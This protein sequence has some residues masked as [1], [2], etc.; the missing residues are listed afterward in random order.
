[1]EPV[2][3]RRMAEAEMRVLVE[4]HP[5]RVNEKDRN[6]ETILYVAA[7]MN[8]S[9]A[10][11]SWLV[12]RGADV[13][14][15]TTRTSWGLTPLHKATSAQAVDILLKAGASPTC[16]TE[17]NRNTPL[18]THCYYLKTVCVERLLR[19]PEVIETID[20]QDVYGRTG[21]FLACLNCKT[22]SNAFEII[23]MLLRAG[24]D[25]TIA[26]E[27]RQTPLAYVRAH[28][29]NN[30]ALIALLEHTTSFLS[31]HGYCLSKARHITAS[32][33]ALTCATPSFLQPRMPPLPRVELVPPAPS[34]SSGNQDADEKEKKKRMAVL[35]FVLGKNE[36]GSQGGMLDELFVELIETL[37]P[38]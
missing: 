35:Q 17:V 18:L 31:P 5:D 10:F 32:H 1:M 6:Y 13:H 7:D 34:S 9:P 30:L 12:E 8:M 14:M 21:L 37:G 11:I 15:R 4:G 26:N 22:E 28:Y 25:P 38:V 33:H 36:D 19:V 2:N 27:D 20:Q 16:V 3:F 29:S 24:A 23:K